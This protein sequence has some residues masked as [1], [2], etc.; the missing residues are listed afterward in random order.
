MLFGEA[1]IDISDKQS[2]IDRQTDRLACWLTDC[3]IDIQTHKYVFK[4][5]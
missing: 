5:H 2:E 3:L 4:R 1:N